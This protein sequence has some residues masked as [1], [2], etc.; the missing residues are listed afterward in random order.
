M[1]D[2]VKRKVDGKLYTATYKGVAYANS[3]KEQYEKNRSSL[4]LSEKLF[5]EVLISPKVDIDDFADMQSYLRVRNFLYEVSQGVFSK[6]K[7]SKAAL[8]RKVRKQWGCWRLIYCDM[9]NFTYD[10]VFHRMSPQE[11]EEANIALDIVEELLK[12]KMKKK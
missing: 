11:I 1:N 3:L 4:S 7:A 8:K 12:K 9:A 10:E 6:E 5:N 2:I